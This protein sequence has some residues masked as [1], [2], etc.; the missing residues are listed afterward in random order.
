[1]TALAAAR[2]TVRLGDSAVLDLLAVPLA[3][4]AKVYQGGV[5][6]VSAGYA[7]AGRANAADQVLGI[8]AKTVDNTAGAAGDLTCEVKQGVFRL[9]N[10][11]STDLIAQANAFSLCYLVDDQTVALTSSTGARPIAGHVVAID[12]LGV[13]VDLGTG[14]DSPAASAVAPQVLSFPLPVLANVA[15]AQ[16]VVN[17]TPGFAGRILSV[18]FQDTVAVTTAAKAATL[19]TNI[20]AAPVT[21][22]VVALAGL[23]AVGAL[24]A[25]TAVTAANTF[26]A[27]Q[28]I[29]VV[30]SAVTAFAEGAGV[31]LITISA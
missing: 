1:M 24:Q 23:Y 11:A 18:G 21:G 4:G 8:A 20:A 12:S 28:A 26:T 31:L 16:T 6:S 30:A 5:V 9:G 10:S 25:G 3:A 17:F 2:D 22:G 29:T 13:F 27:A 19:T 15:N 14:V 7:V